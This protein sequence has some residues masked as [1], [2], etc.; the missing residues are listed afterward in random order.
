MSESPQEGRGR[1]CLQQRTIER[2]SEYDGPDWMI[3]YG[4][5]KALCAHVS[6]EYIRFY[7]TTG[8]SGVTYTHSRRSDGQDLPH[9]SCR[10]TT[11]RDHALVLRTGEWRNHLDD[12]PRVVRN[13]IREYVNLR[14]CS[15]EPGRYQGDPYWKQ[16]LFRDNE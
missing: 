2:M 1:G 3:E 15:F 14:S 16:Q 6:G 8:H 11:E 10:L 13:W 4:D 7:L 9:Y 12:V 5:F